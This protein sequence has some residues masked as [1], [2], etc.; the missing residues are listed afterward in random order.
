M[1]ILSV[2][3]LL[4]LVGSGASYA[5]GIEGTWKASMQG[6]NGD[7]ELIF[8]FKMTDGKLSGVVRTP[9]GDTDITN[10]K[11]TGKKFSFDVSFNDMTIKHDC[12]LQED[13]TISMKATGTPA[14]DMVIVLKRQA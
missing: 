4:L 2:I 7:M 8:V 3:I 10:A 12:T 6:P 5:N 11:V 9:N 1:K 13:D 14:G